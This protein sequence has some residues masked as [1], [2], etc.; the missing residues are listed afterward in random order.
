MLLT[1]KSESVPVLVAQVKCFEGLVVVSDSLSDA[2]LERQLARTCSLFCLGGALVVAID[3][4]V[5][6]R[7]A[8][9]TTPVH[10]RSRRLSRLLIH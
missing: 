6:S 10:W 2:L 3:G 7:A 4:E 9:I 8:S 1:F 5:R